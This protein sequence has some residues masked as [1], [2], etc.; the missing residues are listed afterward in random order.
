MARARARY[1]KTRRAD[2][3]FCFAH[4]KLKRAEYSK[5]E[6]APVAAQ[7]HVQEGYYHRRL[8]GRSRRTTGRV[9]QSGWSIGILLIE[10][11]RESKT[12]AS[13]VMGQRHAVTAVELA[14]TGARL[15][16]ARVCCQCRTRESNS[17]RHE[18]TH[19]RQ[20]KV[21]VFRYCYI[22][23]VSMS[24]QNKQQYL[25]SSY[26]ED[27]LHIVWAVPLFAWMAFFFFPVSYLCKTTT[28]LV[29]DNGLAFCQ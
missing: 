21:E 27:I 13:L 2:V 25:Y 19:E 15:R 29:C 22:F 8:G 9:R 18:E 1:N 17:S 4:L 11:R 16:E 23:P 20:K 10:A 6:E 7:A 3:V 28:C 12:L 24:C 14:Q 26:V 5:G